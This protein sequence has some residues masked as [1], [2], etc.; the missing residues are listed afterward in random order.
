MAGYV[1]QESGVKAGL[2][3]LELI[4]CV[5]GIRGCA[6]SARTAPIRKGK[7]PNRDDPEGIN[8]TLNR[9]TKIPF[10]STFGSMKTTV[11]IP[12]IIL[13]EAMRFSGAATKR[14]AVVTAMADYVQRR[15]MTE[16]AKYLGSCAELMTITEFERVRAE[17]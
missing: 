10:S 5:R 7:K 4:R 14:E 15:K 2:D 9:L 13:Q 11:D 8:E 1:G 17:A 3:G 16:V 12:E 6:G